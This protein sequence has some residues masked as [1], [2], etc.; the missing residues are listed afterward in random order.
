MFFHCFDWGTIEYFGQQPFS[1]LK[2]PMIQIKTSSPDN[3]EDIGV[4]NHGKSPRREKGECHQ[5]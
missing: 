3:W 1:M 2:F 4:Q 5:H